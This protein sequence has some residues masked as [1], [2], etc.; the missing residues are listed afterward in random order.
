[1]PSGSLRQGADERGLLQKGLS[2]T[3]S[4]EWDDR[5]KFARHRLS[6]G[7]PV[8]AECYASRR[9]ID[10][11]EGSIMIS[12][13]VALSGRFYQ[14]VPMLSGKTVARK[15]RPHISQSSGSRS[16]QH[17]LLRRRAVF[18]SSSKMTT[19]HH[20]HQS[21][22]SSLHSGRQSI[23]QRLTKMGTKL[24]QLFVLSWYR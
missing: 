11:G 16:Q 22:G 15:Q 6:T 7:V 5:Y 4:R 10:E 3:A 14:A 21:R 20:L 24:C 18:G 13:S 2:L 19:T 23:G 17:H 8:F 9:W 12:A 1:M